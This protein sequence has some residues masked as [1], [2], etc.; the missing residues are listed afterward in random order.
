MIII[1]QK[2]FLINNNKK[3]KTLFQNFEKLLTS[4]NIL[5][6]DIKY[7]NPQIIH[8]LNLENALNVERYAFTYELSNPKEW[9]AKEEVEK[10]IL[11]DD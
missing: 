7:K 5:A 6:L 11:G 8:L 3:A 2:G 9:Q 10:M 1:A 4:K